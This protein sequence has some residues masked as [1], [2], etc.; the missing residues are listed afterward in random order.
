MQDEVGRRAGVRR[1]GV[2]DVFTKNITTRPS[3][4]LN[5]EQ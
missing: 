3:D 4:I 2:R 1:A 5:L